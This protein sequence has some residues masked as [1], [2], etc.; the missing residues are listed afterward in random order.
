MYKENRPEPKDMVKFDVGL[1]GLVTGISQIQIDNQIHHKKIFK[2][3]CN[4]IVKPI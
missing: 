4:E 1:R 2:I 3:I